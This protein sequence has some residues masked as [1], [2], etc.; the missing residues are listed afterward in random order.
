MSNTVVV[1][2]SGYGHTKR[3]AEAAAEGAHAAL[4]EI[5][6][7]GNIPEAAWQQFD[8]PRVS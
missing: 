3:V 4:I 5:D 1:Y 7:E 8:T 6:G 2:F